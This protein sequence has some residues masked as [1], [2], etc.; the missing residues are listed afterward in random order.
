VG[1]E[2]YQR[3]AVDCATDF[4]GKILV[5]RTPAGR[6]AGI[7]CDVEAYPAFSDDVHHG[8]KKTPRTAVMWNAGGVAYVYLIY[9]VWH[10]FAA[11][12]NRAEVPDVVF[13]R[14]LVPV[15]GIDDMVSQWDK[16]RPPNELTNSPGKLC[17]SLQITNDLYGVDL[18][19]NDLFLEDWGIS[20]DPHAIQATQRI[21]INTRHRGHDAALR[22]YLPQPIRALSPEQ[23]QTPMDLRD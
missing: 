6:V 22:Y 1:R 9:G 10:Q 4:L 7:I 17:R 21:G 3:A 20:I 16:L 19:G 23:V 8:N 14:G 15:E 13:I 12:V 2:F 11:V 5:R 18:T